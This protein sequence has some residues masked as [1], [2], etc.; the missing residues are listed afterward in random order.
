MSWFTRR[1]KLETAKLAEQSNEEAAWC[2]GSGT[3]SILKEEVFQCPPFD[4][5]GSND[6]SKTDANTKDH[7]NPIVSGADDMNMDTSPRSNQSLVSPRLSSPSLGNSKNHLVF[8]SDFE[9]G[10]LDKAARV[11]G[12][13]QL[14]RGI[15][16]TC[17][18][19]VPF[20]SIE[21]RNCTPVEADQ[22]YDLHVRCDLHTT[23]NTQWYYFS[24]TAPLETK[25]STISTTTCPREESLSPPPTMVIH[26][27]SVKPVTYPLSVRFNIVNMMKA[28]SLYNYGMKPVAYSEREN[29]SQTSAKGW[30]HAGDTICYFKNSKSYVKKKK[31]KVVRSKYFT[32]SFT[33]TFEN[34]DT[35]FFAHCFPYTYSNLQSFLSTL[36]SDR[37]IHSFVRRKLLCYSLANNRCDLLTIS[38][39]SSNPT[40]M[41]SRP[42]IIV[43]ARVHPGETNASYMMEGFLKFLTS[44][45]EAAKL[46]REC[47]VFK[48]VP[49][50]NPDGVIHGNYRCSLA[51]VD[52]NRKYNQPDP[53]LHPTIFSMKNL[54]KSCQKD[55]GIFLYLDFHGHSQNKNAFLYGCDPL[56]TN[57]KQVVAGT[58][59]LDSE[60]ASNYSIFSRIFP[61]VLAT[62]SSISAE[63]NVFSSQKKSLI[64]MKRITSTNTTAARGEFSLKDCSLKMQKSK[65]GTGRVVSWTDVHINASYT[66]EISFCGSGN[67]REKKLIKN[68]SLSRNKVLKE[69]SGCIAEVNEELREILKT[70]RTEKHYSQRCLLNLGTQMCLAIAAYGNMGSAPKRGVDRCSEDD[71]V[72]SEFDFENKDSHSEADTSTFLPSLS[73]MKSVEELFKPILRSVV[74]SRGLAA[75]ISD[76]DSFCNHKN[77]T[78]SSADKI[79]I[80][81]EVDLR[82]CF[83]IRS[84][85]DLPSSSGKTLRGKNKKSRRQANGD[86]KAKY[87]FTIEHDV[88]PS[89]ELDV[90]EDM[91][92]DSDPSG[93]DATPLVLSKSK[94]FMKLTSLSK[95]GIL[96]R[97]GGCKVKK[98]KRIHG[99]KNKDKDKDKDKDKAPSSNTSD[100]LREKI[101][102]RHSPAYRYAESSPN[103]ATAYNQ[104]ISTSLRRK[105][106]R[107]RQ[108]SLDP[109][110]RVLQSYH[111][112][113]DIVSTNIEQTR[114]INVLDQKRPSAGLPKST[115][116]MQ[117][118]LSMSPVQKQPTTRIARPRSIMT[119]PLL[120]SETMEKDDNKN[121][122]I[123]SQRKA[124][125]VMDAV[126]SYTATHITPS[127]PS[128]KDALCTSIGSEKGVT[129]SSVIRNRPKSSN[130]ISRSLSDNHNNIT[131]CSSHNSPINHIVTSSSRRAMMRSSELET[132]SRLTNI[133]LGS[134]HMS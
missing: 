57:I 42:V 97:Q 78:S 48:V 73:Q 43:T 20:I 115:S 99:K 5:R 112:F 53:M 21:E 44:E 7:K 32:L 45:D 68:F 134:G 4:S 47:Y 30:K 105:S 87:Q 90:A 38:S 94:S 60:I 65:Q 98:K 77:L 56:Q 116:A 22:E 89:E 74:L 3:P 101:T 132:L 95:N 15:N 33:Y 12:R 131:L 128:T 27:S 36:E 122:L 19:N 11:Y 92:S 67:N 70:Y 46:L 79:R 81:A 2:Y 119:P 72:S 28:D 14:M 24:V 88:Y 106:V 86:E 80:Q 123:F 8:D 126:R 9:S 23:G 54:L 55:R 124:P 49:M 1:E 10:N 69:D 41:M 129:K 109:G 62:I 93:D 82:N 127:F 111:D 120:N 84:S 16:C 103:N 18:G 118:P 58:N 34:P 59:E 63:E 50:L 75:N 83:R 29:L 37:R 133:D 66:V 130:A 107:D 91:G 121:D 64:T 35:V 85:T 52:L 76:D 125:S 6:E 108:L 51:G 104:T 113:R 26:P 39:P 17:A 31:D 40:T 61:K 71:D 114:S 110:R 13:N 117:L 100:D 25:E 102:G 96:S